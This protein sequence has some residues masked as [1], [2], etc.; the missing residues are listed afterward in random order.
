MRKRPLYLIPLALILALA[1]WALADWT[2]RE[3]AIRPLS[4]KLSITDPTL[5]G[6]LHTFTTGNF[7]ITLSAI[8]QESAGGY[9][10]PRL[11]VTHRAAPGR[12]LWHTRRGQA[13][14]AAAVGA[15]QISET[16][17]SYT[18]SDALQRTCTEQTIEGIAEVGSSV[19]IS[20]ALVCS[21]GQKIGYTLGFSAADQNQLSFALS[22]DD[23]AFNR[24]YL[25]YASDSDEHFFGFGEQF[26]YF[27]LKGRRVPIWVSEQGIGR[28]QQPVTFLVDLAAKSGGSA[29]ATY[30]AV[31]QYI[32]SRLRSLFLENVEY[33][34]FDLRQADQVQI[35]TFASMIS[36]R[37]LYGADP[38]ALVS[39]YTAWAG[40]MRPLPDWIL[41]GA[42]VGLQGGTARVE[43]VYRQL[44][45]LGTPVSAFWLQDWVGQRQTSF[46][47]QLWWNWELDTQRYP[48]WDALRED[49]AADGVRLMVY[50]SP[51]LADIAGLKPD[52]RRNLYQEAADAGYLVLDASGA[53]YRIQN[54]DFS[55]G[56]V[57]LTNPA[58]VA[59]YKNVLEEQVVGTGASG[60]MADFG[61]ALPCDAVFHSGAPACDFHNHYP[62]A[63]ARLN[64]ELIDGLTNGEEY[65]FFTRSAFS[66]SPAYTT[67]MWE[68]DQLVSWDAHD[69]IKSA[70]TGLLSGGISGFSLNHSDIGGYTGINNPL[71][72]IGRD[73]ELLL[74]WM[75]LS[76]FTTIYRTHEGNTPDQ[77]AQFYSDAES[78]AH[79]D[80]F[81][82]VYRA[83]G[84]LRKRLVQ[85]AAESGVPVVRPLF[86]HYPDDPVTYD[87]SYQEFL[88][89]PDIL[90]A[91][92]LDPGKDSLRVYLPAG[93]WVHVWSGKAY[94]S[95]YEGQWVTVA[96]PLGQPAAFVKEGTPD[97]QQFIENLK[98][99]GLVE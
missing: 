5:A 37:I 49:L 96:A 61:E 79:F 27:D 95:P 86:L 45:A 19:Q 53:P 6:G 97:G 42:V 50:T 46:G 8:G 9:A 98:A 31:P 29:A 84:F 54:T 82:R 93:N 56:L 99:E 20:G 17:G 25:T 91:P 67:L 55:A 33:T 3:H 69:G 72:K 60:W 68:G 76:A 85:G 30:A 74:R 87:L 64:R 22:I 14:A 38:E 40:R 26:S 80:R 41:E 51:F 47:K 58:A 70:V 90:V 75:E 52:V 32:T 78:F 35:S 71:L 66:Q 43:E 12:W 77:N 92:V 21:N 44:K 10:G 23:Q 89:G 34:V 24:A 15:A 83:W 2:L 57:D 11:V 36:G 13:F 7:D 28:G 1:A 62:E 81:A 94:R 73:K 88:V 39:E 48:G 65:V 18:I 59:W 16:R 63:W 4:G